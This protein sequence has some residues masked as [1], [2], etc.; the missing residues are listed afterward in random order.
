MVRIW[1]GKDFDEDNEVIYNSFSSIMEPY[2]YLHI[3]S[4]VSKTLDVTLSTKISSGYRIT[5][6]LIKDK[7]CPNLAIHESDLRECT[8]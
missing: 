3:K 1:P 2:I 5:V 7:Y 4:E 8:R 6:D